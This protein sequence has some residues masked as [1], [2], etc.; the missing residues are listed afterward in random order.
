MACPAE[1]AQPKTGSF[2]GSTM[3]TSVPAKLAIHNLPA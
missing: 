1:S 3:M 2:A